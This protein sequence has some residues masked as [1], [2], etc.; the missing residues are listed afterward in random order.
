MVQEYQLNDREKELLTVLGKNPEM[1]LKGLSDHT[2]YRRESSIVRKIKQF[3]E[4]DFLRGPVYF[5]D[6]GKLCKNALHRLFC[7]VELKES[8][9][10]VIEYLKLIESLQW[11]Y[12]V[13]SSRKELLCAAF[14]SSND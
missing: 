1:S 9:E 10:T 2:Q 8:P 6:Y 13:L 14:L 11:V 4:Q 3:R 12:P 7:I 5:V